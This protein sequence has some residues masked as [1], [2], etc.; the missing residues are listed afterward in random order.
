VACGL[1]LALQPSPAVAPHTS[2]TINQPPVKEGDYDD[3]DDHDNDACL[4]STAQ[5]TA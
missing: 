4:T 1:W 2:S 3:D 5:P